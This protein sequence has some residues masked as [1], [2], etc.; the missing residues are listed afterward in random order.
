MD[1]A[2]FNQIRTTEELERTYENIDCIFVTNVFHHIPFCEH[3]EWMASLNRILKDKG[4]IVCFEHNPYNPV[5]KYKTYT[6]FN[7]ENKFGEGMLKPVYCRSLM[8]NANMKNVKCNFT[9]FF[10]QRNNIFISIEKALFWLPLGAQY[11]V[12]G[13][14]S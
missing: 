12:V 1:Y 8:K 3:Q 14:K 5:V 10:L 6:E 7:G 4:V 13:K 9:L 11:F 2:N